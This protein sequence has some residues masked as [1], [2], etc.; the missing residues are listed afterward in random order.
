M[1]DK[2]VKVAKIHASF[3]DKETGRECKI[4]IIITDEYAIARYSD[5]GVAKKIYQ[6]DI[7]EG[8]K[9]VTFNERKA[10]ITEKYPGK[11]Y[12]E[13][14]DYIYAWMKKAKWKQLG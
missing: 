3:K 11:T 12:L 5:I 1:T 14:R 13:I 9:N 6:L 10:I 7:K 2:E 8:N 4:W